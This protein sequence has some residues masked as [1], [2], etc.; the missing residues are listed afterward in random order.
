MLADS[1]ATGEL[2]EEISTES[3][4]PANEHTP[5]NGQEEGYLTCLGAPLNTILF[6]WFII[7]CIWVF[8]TDETHC[9]AVLYNQSKLYIIASL[10]LI[11]VFICCGVCAMFCFMMAVVVGAEQEKQMKASGT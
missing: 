6:V 1:A 3:L 11:P 9:D 4:K 7:G 2:V 8:S 5:L 10:C